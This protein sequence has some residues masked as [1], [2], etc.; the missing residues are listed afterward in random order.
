MNQPID[1]FVICH[2]PFP[3]LLRPKH[4]PTDVHVTINDFNYEFVLHILFLPSYNF[5]QLKVEVFPAKFR[6]RFSSKTG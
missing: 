6:A 4:L 3:I 1:I 5:T 2:L